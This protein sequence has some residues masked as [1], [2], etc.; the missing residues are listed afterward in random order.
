[1]PAPGPYGSRRRD[2]LCDA[3]WRAL[4]LSE[5]VAIRAPTKTVKDNPSRTSAAS[6][7]GDARWPNICAL[8]CCLHDPVLPL[9]HQRR[10]NVPSREILRWR[11][12]RD[13]GRIGPLTIRRRRLHVL[14]HLDDRE[15]NPWVGDPQE[16]PD[17]PCALLGVVGSWTR[18]ERR[19]RGKPR[20]PLSPCVL[21]QHCKTPSGSPKPSG[22]SGA[23]C[24]GPSR[25]DP[26]RLRPPDVI[27]GD[28]M[29]NFPAG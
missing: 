7:S 18:F 10:T 16:C 27:A 28:S 13:G 8:H 6:K 2:A 4:A 5:T 29:F 19:R 24:A 26:R 21:F 25:R 14:D 23:R 11:C 12:P 1:M 17:E 15:A 20:A 9:K 22:R 3:G